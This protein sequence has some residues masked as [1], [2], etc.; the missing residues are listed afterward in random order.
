M[1][2]RSLFLALLLAAPLPAQTLDAPSA[3]SPGVGDSYFPG[4]GNG[5]YDALDYDLTIEFRPKGGSIDGLTRIRARAT[6]ALSAF[7]LELDG[8]EVLAVQ[9]DGR[10]ATFSRAGRELTVTPAVPIAN[11][12][13][14]DVVVVYSG[15]PKPVR[16]DAIPVRVGW[17]TVAG[18][19]YVFSEPVGAASFYPVNDHPSDKATYTYRVTAP[20][21]LMV[22]ANGNLI[23]VIDNDDQRT[24]HWRASEPMA[25]YL[26]TICIGDFD[27]EEST[28]ENG[29]R[30]RFFFP[31]GTPEG[32]RMPFRKTAAMVEFFSEK[33]GP[34]PFEACGGV[35]TKLGVPGALETQT[36]PVYG[37]FAGGERVIAH[38]IA[39]QWWGD[40]VGFARW[41]DIWLAE[42]FAEYGAWLWKGH[43]E[44]EVAFLEHIETN[45]EMVRGQRIGPP[46]DPGLSKMFGARTYVRGP[47]A[48]HAVRQALGDEPFFRVLRE[49][50]KRFRHGNAS[51][52]DFLKVI[53]DETGRELKPMLDAWLY[54]EEIPHDREV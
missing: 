50:Q 37:L 4:L 7:N 1:M 10:A 30:Y 36:L 45:Y 43:T 25:S 41:Q 54:G 39:H 34:Y 6:Q 24:Y 14:F 49:F 13:E 31:T 51:I 32:R 23:E 26:V 21:P 44:G 12:S 46:G 48:V 5:G 19:A 53:R 9:V 15:R 42:G 16:T 20:K 29:L 22:A 2:L 47:W 52:D 8:L 38:E 17:W 40:S 18:E 11:D 28:D 3:G 27:L 33:F 35:L